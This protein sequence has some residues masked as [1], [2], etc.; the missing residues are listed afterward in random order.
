MRKFLVFMSFM[1]AA[2]FAVALVMPGAASADGDELKVKWFGYIQST[3]EQ[4]DGLMDAETDDDNGLRFGADRIRIGYKAKK[5]KAFSKLQVDFNKTGTN[6]L[7]QIIKDAEVGY[8]LH[9]AASVK[10][11][12]FKT[13]VGMDFNGSGAKLDITKRGMEKALVLERSSG[14]MLSGRK[15][16]PGLSYDIGVFNPTTRSSVV[17]GGPV[18]DAIAYAGRIMYDR[19]KIV[20]AEAS[21]GVSEQAGSAAGSDDYKVFDIGAI[22]HIASATLKAEYISGENM[23]GGQGDQTVWF[24]HAG[25]KVNSMFEPV[26]RYYQGDYNDLTLGNTFLGLNVFVNSASRLQLNYVLASG[27]QWNWNGA[28]SGD[29][30]WSKAGVYPDNTFLA[31]YQVKF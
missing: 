15:I 22:S 10:I 2:V 13:P 11:G 16:G 5:G 27:D 28:G 14:L 6:I 8:K 17:S 24:L 25:Y 4:G 29:K 18:G 7:P 23:K 26:I 30:N 19:G 9:S 12:I 3:V 1:V 21:Y 20:H 31:Q